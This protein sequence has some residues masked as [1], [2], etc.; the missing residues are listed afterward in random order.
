MHQVRYG[1][2]PLTSKEAEDLATLIDLNE[3]GKKEIGI[4]ELSDPE[5]SIKKLHQAAENI[6][7]LKNALLATSRYLDPT[8]T[9]LFITRACVR[10][11]YTNAAA[12]AVAETLKDF[13]D[14]MATKSK[15]SK[16]WLYETQTK[17]SQELMDKETELRK[18]EAPFNAMSK[19]MKKA[20]DMQ[21]LKS[22]LEAVQ[23][24]NKSM[25]V[26]IDQH[27]GKMKGLADDIENLKQLGITGK[28]FMLRF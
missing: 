19:A 14:L 11:E 15:S 16:I 22:K 13:D 3:G 20:L 1:D 21:D 6:I 2:Q 24:V 25:A 23:R 26:F 12:T 8:Q 17:L 18:N 4:G 27:G 7:I 9:T 10:L 28:Y 5:L